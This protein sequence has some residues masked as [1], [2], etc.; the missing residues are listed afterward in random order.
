[1]RKKNDIPEISA[2]VLLNYLY[3]EMG[4]KWIVQN[5]GT[6]YRNYNSDV[7]A[8]DDERM[9]VETARDSFI[10]LLPQGLITDEADLRGKG[11]A[12]KFKSLQQRLRLLRETFKP[13]DTL[14]FRDSMYIEQQVDSLLQNKLT[15]ILS[16]YFGVNPEEIE[17]PYV[18]EAIVLLPYVNE[19]R[20]DMGFVKDMLNVIV[21][22]DVNMT[23]GRYSHSDSTKR[24]LPKVRYELLIPNMSP[25]EY[26]TKTAELQPLR[27]FICEW[28]MPVEVWCQIDIKEHHVELQTNTRLTLGYN[29]E[30]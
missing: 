9:E 11:A 19:H 26:R 3:P 1:M 13:I 25:E 23:I 20:G 14:H 24:W 7:L 15:Y 16:T 17:N 28:F 6:F 4:N 8:I 27:D 21:K 18:R 12:Q 29:T 22:C 10:N 2:E 5:E 30:L